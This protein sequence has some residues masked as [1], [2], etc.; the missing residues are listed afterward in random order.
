[1]AWQKKKPKKKPKLGNGEGTS[2]PSP[3][4]DL[5]HALRHI[6]LEGPDRG[7]HF[8]LRSFFPARRGTIPCSIRTNGRLEEEEKY[9]SGAAR[10]TVK[11]TVQYFC[12]RLLCRRAYDLPKSSCLQ[13]TSLKKCHTD[14]VKGLSDGIFVCRTSLQSPSSSTRRYPP[15]ID[16][17]REAVCLSP[18][19]SR[20]KVTQ[21]WPRWNSH[22]LQ[23]LDAPARSTFE[24]VR[25][26]TFLGKLRCFS[27]RTES[28]DQR[29]NPPC[30]VPCTFPRMAQSYLIG[31]SMRGRP[32]LPL[33]SV[34]AIPTMEAQCAVPG[35]RGGPRHLS[36]SM[37]PFISIHIVWPSA[38]V[39]PSNAQFPFMGVL[40]RGSI[41]SKKRGIIPFHSLFDFLYNK[42]E[43]P[44]RYSPRQRRI[45]R[46]SPFLSQGPFRRPEKAR[47][48]P[49]SRP[50]SMSSC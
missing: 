37:Y 26:C 19:V 11:D 36:R 5:F 4:M 8:C 41:R 14:S 15:M 48:I 42:R 28:R 9:E 13:N 46:S 3:F 47:R 50:E 1:M 29:R 17:E 20:K 25:H 18:P 43:G 32:R 2:P 16:Q 40:P 30:F 38:P 45:P 34:H 49:R 24:K 35:S 44:E 10:G 21:R 39:F 22:Q 31:G 23:E 27:I 7:R 12:Q 33:S 6:F